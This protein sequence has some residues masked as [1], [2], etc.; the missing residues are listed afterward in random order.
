[1]RLGISQQREGHRDQYQL[2]VACD[3]KLVAANSTAR[4]FSKFRGLKEEL[5]AKK[6]VSEY[7]QQILSSRISIWSWTNIPAYSCI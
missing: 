3:L 6:Y 7:T 1:M 4:I 5:K 2:P